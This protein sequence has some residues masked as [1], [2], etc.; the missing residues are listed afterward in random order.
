MNKDIYLKLSASLMLAVKKF[1]IGNN[2]IYQEIKED[3]ET[4]VAE[5]DIS[6]WCANI[7]GT[8]KN[9]GHIIADLDD[10]IKEGDRPK[11]VE[12]IAILRCAIADINSAYSNAIDSM[13][14][15]VVS[16]RNESD[17]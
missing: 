9:V 17:D 13:E 5:C 2:E 11:C 16:I 1:L 6:A 10:A 14:D 15:L 7:D 8:T 12:S 3:F 4:I